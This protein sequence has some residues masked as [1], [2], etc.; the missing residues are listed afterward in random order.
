MKDANRPL[1]LVLGCSHWHRASA[2]R[3]AFR[4]EDVACGW[5]DAQNQARTTFRR[6]GAG[7]TRHK[8]IPGTIHFSVKHGRIS[9]MLC[10]ARHGRKVIHFLVPFSNA[11]EDRHSVGSDANGDRSA[12]SEMPCI[13]G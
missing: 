1:R 10:V 4:I 11:A 5:A 6:E 9:R 12:R 3:A 13:D 7:E 2:K 8:T